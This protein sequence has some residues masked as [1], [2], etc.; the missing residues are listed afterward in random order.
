M[1]QA[2]AAVLVG[3]T[4]TAASSSRPT[5]AARAAVAASPAQAL[6]T[7][8]DRWNQGNMIGWGPTLARVSIRQLSA[9]QLAAVGL[10]D[11]ALVR[12]AISLAVYSR[13]DARTGCP[14]EAVMPGHPKFCLDRRS[15]YVCV[16]DGL[17]AYECPT[18]AE[19]SPPLRNENATT[20]ESG[21]LS[22]DVPLKGTRVT[23]RLGWQRR[24]PHIDGFIY[25]WTRAG[26]LRQGLT[27]FTKEDRG[28]CST[29]SEQT[30]AKSAL[31]CLSNVIFDPCFPQS[32]AWDH[33]GGVVACASPGATTFAR[34][35]ITRRS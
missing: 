11:P 21:A 23:P 26:R 20:D 14:G 10:Q 3:A 31:R 28:T 33:R 2:M 6:R 9:S 13:R 32:A 18:N 8:V 7:C 30:V 1:R 24:Y 4:L 12:C 19:G 5:A 16:I 22:L 27:F 35:V 17:G 25:P 34:F 29:G 15:T